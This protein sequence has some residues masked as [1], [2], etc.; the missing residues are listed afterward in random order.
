MNVE[1]DK[2]ANRHAYSYFFDAQNAQWRYY[3]IF[4]DGS[5]KSSAGG[6]GWILY[7]ANALCSDTLHEWHVVASLSFPMAATS[8]ITTC[9]L[10]ACVWAVAF[11]TA[12]LEGI[13]DAEAVLRNWQTMETKRFR[14]LELANLVA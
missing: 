6:G 9:E 1:A 3:R 12:L 7:G 8:T 14:V 10:E 13:D 4:F 5:L 2:L 11:I